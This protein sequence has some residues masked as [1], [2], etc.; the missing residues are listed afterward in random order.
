MTVREPGSPVS[1]Q[2]GQTTGNTGGKGYDPKLPFG[3]EAKTES[4]NY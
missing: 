2:I 1:N 3:I 4:R